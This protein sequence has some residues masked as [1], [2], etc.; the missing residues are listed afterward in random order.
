VWAILASQG[1]FGHFRE[2]NP[3]IL[4]N[5]SARIESIIL[6]VENWSLLVC[7]SVS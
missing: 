6:F 1:D 2:N 5:R 4:E 7:E 3:I